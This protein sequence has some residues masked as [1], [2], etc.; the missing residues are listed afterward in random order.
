MLPVNSEK[1]YKDA[2]ATAIFISALLELWEY[3]DNSQ[4]YD[5]M[6]ENVLG[7]LVND[8][9]STVTESSGILLHCAYNVNSENPYDWDAAPS[10]GD[11][12]FLEAIK[13]C[14]LMN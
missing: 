4:K 14:L 2:S 3:V 9:L 8:Y 1:K 6:I 5:E 12:Y 7:I 10:W 13:R 11:Y